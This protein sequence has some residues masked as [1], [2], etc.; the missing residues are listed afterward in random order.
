MAA[1]APE[2]SRPL[3]NFSLPP[4]LNWGTQK[5][6]RC[7]KITNSNNPSSSNDAVSDSI[8]ASSGDRKLRNASFRSPQPPS[9]RRGEVDNEIEVIRER[10]MLN[11]RSEVDKIHADYLGNSEFTPAIP[12]PPPPESRPWNLRTRRSPATVEI[13]PATVP[14]EVGVSGGDGGRAKF[15]VPLSRNEIEDDFV[16]MTGRRPPRKPKKRS[17]YVQRQLDTLFPGLWLSEISPEMYKV[18]ETPEAPK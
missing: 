18:N 11:L 16:E 6:L 13:S 1:M 7:A 2:R 12:P 17:R 9:I 4:R 10:L 3:H 8:P 14:V 15:S 5:L